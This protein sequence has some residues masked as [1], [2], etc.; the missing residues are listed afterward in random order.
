MIISPCYF[1]FVVAGDVVC[2]CFTSLDF[3]GVGFSIAYVFGSIANFLGLEF[4]F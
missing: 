4:S 3:D 2:V 1:G